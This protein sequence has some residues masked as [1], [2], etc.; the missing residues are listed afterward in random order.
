[1]ESEKIKLDCSN[2]VTNL[3]TECQKEESDQSTL[4]WLVQKQDVKIDSTDAIE[5]WIKQHDGQGYMV[6][7][8]EVGDIVIYLVQPFCDECCNT[9]FARYE[10]THTP[11]G[12]DTRS[13]LLGRI[14][15][16][17]RKSEWGCFVL[18]KQHLAPRGFPNL[19][20]RKEGDLRLISV[21][22][23][24]YVR[25]RKAGFPTGTLAVS[26][27][28][29]K[30]VRENLLGQLEEKGLN[31]SIAFL[32]MDEK[33]VDPAAPQA[34][35]VT[36]LTGLLLPTDVILEFRARFLKLLP[37]FDLGS[38]SFDTEIHAADL[39]RNH[40]DE[41]HFRFYRGL[42][43]LVNDLDCKVYRRGVCLIGGS[44]VQKGDEAEVIAQCYRSILI[45]VQEFDDS[46]QVWPVMETDRSYAQDRYFAGYGRWMDHATTYLEE[47]GEGV[48]ELIDDDYMVDNARFGEVHYV[49]KRSIVGNAV[50]CLAYVLHAKWLV[51]HGTNVSGYKAMLAECASEL[52]GTKVH[53]YVG[54]FSWIEDEDE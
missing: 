12:E 42:V 32:Y 9:V 11:E 25:P 49:T 18:D 53:D 51:E 31:D 10:D 21:R 37:S 23:G 43:S 2:D 1:M 33:Y 46:A 30:H 6:A 5:D 22:G 54:R 38:E 17:L 35:R 8:P 45:D 14:L 39:F 19:A 28:V 15:G 41:V 4:A 3:C 27:N 44:Q 29:P 26:P 13:Q 50:D 52:D 16:E 7:I 20:I 34:E 36:S 48:E 40:D 47:E 24:A